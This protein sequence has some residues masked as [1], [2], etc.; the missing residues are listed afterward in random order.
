M[1]NKGSTEKIDKEELIDSPFAY[2]KDELYSLCDPKNIKLLEEYGGVNGLFI[3]LQSSPTFG[4]SSSETDNFEK[5]VT[6]ED[7]KI[8]KTSSEISI[9]ASNIDSVHDNQFCV[10][11]KVF[12]ENKVPPVKQ[13]SLFELMIAALSDKTMIMLCIAACV[14]LAIGIYQDTTSDD[15][16]PKVH[17]V[18]GCA[19]LVAVVI[20][21][22]VGSI[23]DYNKEKRFRKL[24]EK[25]EDRMVKAFRDGQNTL[26]SVYDVQTGDILLLEPGDIICADGVLIENQNIRCD[27]SSST[28]ESDTIKKS[29]NEDPFII[30]GS[31][32]LE[33]MGKYIVTGVGINS[34]HGRT[35]MGLRVE[36]EETPLQA[37]LNILAEQIAKVGALA[38]VLM[39]IVL[40]VKYVIVIIL[41]NYCDD[42]NCTFQKVFSQVTNIV[43][44]AITIIVVAVPEGLPL[45]VTL[46]LAFAATR[47][48][49]DNCLVRLI[50]SCEIMG[51]ATVICSDK[52]GTLTENKMTVVEAVYGRNVHV[53]GD[54]EIRNSPK[55]LSGLYINNPVMQHGVLT[56]TELLKI[57]LENISINS[58]AF[59]NVDEETH[60][61]V[62][63]GSKTETALLNFCQK[64][65]GDYMAYRESKYIKQIQ[66]YPF[67][68]ERKSMTTLIEIN[69]NSEGIEDHEPIYRVHIKGA[70]EIVLGY[71][72]HAM[73]LPHPKDRQGEAINQELNEKLLIDFNE[74]VIRRFAENSL[75]TICLAYRDLTKSEYKEILERVKKE[76][77]QEEKEKREA[78]GENNEENRTE[79]QHEIDEETILSHPNA[80]K[81]LLEKNLVCLAIVGI[82]DPVREG[83]P[84]AIKICQ[85]AGVS[86]KMVTGDNIDTA[87]SIAKKCGIYTKGGIVMEGCDFRKLSSD[88]MDNI[89]GKLQ[90]LARSSPMDKQLLVQHLKDIGET[91]AVTGD[92]TNDGP[93]LKRADVGFSMGISGTEVAKEASSIVLMDDNFASIVKAMLWGRSVND[94][95]KK[96]IQF[97]LTVNVSAVLLA[98]ISSVI[99]GN[100]SGALTAIQLLWVNLIMDTLAALALATES[101]SIDLLDRPP[102]LKNAP[103]ISIP[104]WKMIIGMAILQVIVGNVLL[105]LGPKMFKLTELSD[106][107]GIIKT[108]NN[109]KDYYNRNRAKI[110]RSFAKFEDTVD[111]QKKTIKTMVFN[112]FVYMQVFNE[113]NC[114]VI[115]NELNVF[116]GIHKNAYFYCIFLFVA[117]AQ[118]FIVQYGGTIFQT[119]K[120][121]WWQFLI[122]IGIGVFSLPFA[123]FLRLI[124][125]KWFYCF[126]K[127]QEKIAPKE[128]DD[129][130]IEASNTSL[131]SS[132]DKTTLRVFRTVRGGRLL[133]LSSI[134]SLNG[135]QKIS[136]SNG[137]LNK[138]RRES[139]RKSQSIAI[140]IPK[141]DNS[142][143]ANIDDEEKN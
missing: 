72:S 62:F 69:L 100:E 54:N 18:E 104:M 31:K 17:W 108:R 30:S 29:L 127:N 58:T 125:D 135:S 50:A 60:Q 65:G 88:E 39:L 91:V 33:G 10:R 138:S 16:E 22:L 76:I 136:Y 119:I 111:D 133:S 20:V 116:K 36:Q 24:N 89:V 52:T 110:G 117:I 123:V 68:S 103:L 118:F 55:I 79:H 7:C 67:S 77:E 23:N 40:I 140:D 131:N 94:S 53:A 132:L 78:K 19:I 112:T 70:S 45:A 21:V 128:I 106:V 107:G 12:G 93:A 11:K 137:S 81:Y 26:I 86:V 90:V 102:T 43:I 3:G 97:Q 61:I 32:V 92:G 99:D 64:M 105:F 139:I 80:L 83:V 98:F 56:G 134:T 114:R 57:L 126:F 87:R 8:K 35:M 129:E 46:T 66:T 34:F 63:I 42:D 41:T 15:D 47:M 75:R 25:K 6:R 142:R 85:R 5:H 73:I 130:E 96:F 95:V 28:G 74:N 121:N 4:L 14:S 101:P 115:T 120:L 51:S 44:A 27:E 48:I 109:I 38:A 37:K 59:E 9:L 82:E 122:C 113:I 141:N 13:T 124:P 1:V 71:C 49:K 143:Q 2:T 84:E